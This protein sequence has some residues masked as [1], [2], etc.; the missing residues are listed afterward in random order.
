MKNCGNWKALPIAVLLA[1]QTLFGAGCVTAARTAEA[2]RLDAAV[3]GVMP[4]AP[5]APEMRSVTFEDKDGGLWLS[6]ADYRALEKNILAM[7][8]YAARLE[9][10]IEFYREDK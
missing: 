4:E 2:A 6:Y 8:E 7:R 10:I 1:A 3:R 9:L 5:P